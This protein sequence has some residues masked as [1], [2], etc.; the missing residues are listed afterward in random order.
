[1]EITYLGKCN[2]IYG[3]GTNAH[4]LYSTETSIEIASAQPEL[5]HF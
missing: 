3:K 2:I 1:M 5:L 4:V